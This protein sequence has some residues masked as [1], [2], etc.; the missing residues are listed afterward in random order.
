MRH[1]LVIHRNNSPVKLYIPFD[2][3]HHDDGSNHKR[4]QTGGKS[5]RLRSKNQL[6]QIK[7]SMDSMTTSMPCLGCLLGRFQQISGM[8][9]KPF[10][11]RKISIT[12]SKMKA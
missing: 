10:K 1:F 3:H 11:S 6:E 8:K 12:K 5:E 9:M 2:R 4:V 7:T